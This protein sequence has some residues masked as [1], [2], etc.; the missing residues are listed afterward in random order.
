MQVRTQYI[1]KARKEE[2]KNLEN[3]TDIDISKFRS[4]SVGGMFVNPF[5]EYRPQTAFEF[6]L[7]R[8]MQLLK[9]FM[10]IRSSFIKLP[11]PH[12]GAVEVE[13]ILKVFK[14]DLERFRKNSEVLKS[15]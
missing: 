5:E 12:D 14:P 15:A 2:Y 10:V 4:T 13:D 6:I 11:Q 9:V 1:I 7:V 8:I 3:G